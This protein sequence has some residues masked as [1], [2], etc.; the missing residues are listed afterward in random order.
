MPGP[1]DSGAVVSG[2]PDSVVPDGVLWPDEFHMVV[3]GGRLVPFVSNYLL[4]RVC[5]GDAS[6]LAKAWAQ[7]VKSPLSDEE[8]ASLPRVAQYYSVVTEVRKAHVDYLNALKEYMLVQASRDPEVDQE[9]VRPLMRERDRRQAENFS[10]IARN[11]GYP[12]FADP[13]RD[14]LR[15]LAEL[16]LPIY[17]TT[18]PHMF[19]EAALARTGFKSAETEVFYWGPQTAGSSIFERE[20]DYRPTV[21]RPLVYHL[22]GLDDRPES[23]VLSEDDYMTVFSR[24]SDLKHMVKT[25]QSELS[26]GGVNYDIPSDLKAAL[27]TSGLLLIGYEIE[28]WEF[29]VLFRWLLDY[30]GKSRDGL[31]PPDA[32][33]LQVQRRTQPGLEENNRQVEQYLTKFFEQKHFKVYWGDPE[34]CVFELWSRWK[35]TTA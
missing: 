20:P 34:S 28:D 31:G 4:P 7:R 16:P 32:F 15:L 8:N 19:L 27:S 3:N 6:D 1:T 25:S 14:P 2:L 35:G 9:Y 33:C 21:E 12:K 22:F 26:S 30:F 17:V 29:R 13:T 11:V 10:R 18:C 24:L 23:I 5:G